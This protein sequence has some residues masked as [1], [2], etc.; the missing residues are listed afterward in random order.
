MPELTLTPPAAV[1]V[2][3]INCP[4]P[5]DAD[6]D[7]TAAESMPSVSEHATEA[8]ASKST[9]RLSKEPAVVS[10]PP[11]MKDTGICEVGPTDGRLSRVNAAAV[12]DIEL[13]SNG[14]ADGQDTIAHR[15]RSISSV[16][17]KSGVL[18]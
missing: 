16:T 10:V 12:A 13:P 17:W 18:G 15:G 14:A 5:A 11:P 7:L 6:T 3:N 1:T 9:P 4:D 2:P 8:V